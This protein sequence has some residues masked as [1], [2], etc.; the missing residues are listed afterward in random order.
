MA[1]F[2]QLSSKVVALAPLA[3]IFSCF[4]LTFWQH[5]HLEFQV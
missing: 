2:G 5:S 3:A 4:L 1:G